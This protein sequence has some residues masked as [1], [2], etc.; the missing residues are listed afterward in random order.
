M[1]K[2]VL[3]IIP[4]HPQGKAQNSSTQI[5]P[6]EQASPLN[7]ALAKSSAI[8][9]GKTHQQHVCESDN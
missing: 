8:F 9:P 5:N 6:S 4:V 1:S 7:P 3:Y 2:Y